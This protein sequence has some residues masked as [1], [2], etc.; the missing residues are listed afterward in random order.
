MIGSAGDLVIVTFVASTNTWNIYV[1]GVLKATTTSMATYMDATTDV[2]ELRFGD[3]SGANVT[4]YPDSYDELGGWP[5]R[6]SNIFV[7]NGTAFDATAV[8]E[9]VADKADLTTSDNY[10]SF[11]TYATISGSGITGVLGSATYSRGDVGFAGTRAKVF[12]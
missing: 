7:A 11:T 4:S 12:S 2:S 3:V 8:T 1:E 9:I 5:W 6:L 10:S